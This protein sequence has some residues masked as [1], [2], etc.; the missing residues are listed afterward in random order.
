MIKQVRI[1]NF[2]SLE[3][4]DVILEMSNVLIGQN[5]SGKTNFLKAIDVA[6][7]GNHSISEEDI[8]ITE[9]ERLK[10]DKSAIIDILFL[11]VNEIGKKEQNF[12]VFW[13]SVFT[14]NWITTD[15]TNGDYVGIRTQIQ[16]DAKRNDYS[17]I[18]KRIIEWGDTSLNNSKVG[19]KQQISID[20]WD[21]INSFFMD[22]QRDASSDIKNKKSYFGR[23]T[24][25]ID[26][27]DAQIKELEGKLDEVNDAIID[28][29]PALRQTSDK[30]D[31]MGRTIGNTDG[32]I[33]IEPMSRKL[34]D[35]HKG[36]DIAYKDGQAASFSISQHGMGTRSWVTFLTLGAYV[37]W[38]SL[39]I[40]EEEA[41]NYVMLTLEEPEAHLHPQAQKQL[42]SQISQFNGQKII[43]THSPYV[44]A[45][46]ELADIMHF[47]KES[48]KTQVSRFNQGEY[49]LE[50]KNRIRREVINTRGDLLFSTA[51]VLCE[52]ITEEQALPIFF[53]EY[54]GKEV[55]F[56]GINVIGIG[57]QNYKTFLNLIKDFGIKW[58][59]FSDGE[60]EA[61]KCVTKAVKIMT[62]E[63]INNL[64][65]V[66]ILDN[67]EDY[68]KHLLASGCG[69]AIIKAINNVEMNDNF[70]SNQLDTRNHTNT[71]RHKTNKPACDKCGQDIYEDT[72]RQYDGEGGYKQAIYDC[73]TSKSGKAKYASEVA[74]TIIKESTGLNK[75]PPKVRSLFNEMA[76][77]LK[78]EIR[79][80]YRE[81]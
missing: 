24:S 61:K 14:D 21:Y 60:R 47:Y 75:I 1:E 43:S 7:N 69:S 72:I 35:L 48:G 8:Y 58:F 51:V 70:F 65:N 37:D 57:G 79:G 71:G 22:A 39:K 6:L 76:I 3:S 2:R 17:I 38:I 78:L 12:S 68:E 53:K 45:Q 31:E 74:V 62:D 55:S 15:E 19:K 42:Y 30:I 64:E 36:M 63:S 46:V 56:L 9:N 34:N 26:L 18:R 81:N 54:F 41:E 73:C 40:K 44:V 67:N 20:T 52:G 50:E 11:P 49:T 29:I 80:E 28:G 32:K 66:V 25:Q 33:S 59:I 4:V 23:T 27:T 10:P 13:T 77:Q 16:F 5:N